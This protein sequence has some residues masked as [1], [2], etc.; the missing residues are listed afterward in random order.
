[1]NP[2]W[3]LL[4]SVG[5][6][7]SNALA[8]SP[9]AGDV[10]RSFPGRTA[11][12]V[13]LASAV[14]GAGT[15]VGALF[16]APKA[17][18]IGLQKALRWALIGLAL[19]LSISAIAPAIW[20]L[21]A[22]QA[23]A[24]LSAGLALPAIY[25]LA[26]DVAPKGRESETL[27]K[28][29]TGWTLS[30]VAGVT[31]SASVSDWAHWRVVYAALAVLTAALIAAFGRMDIERGEP[32]PATSPLQALRIPG[33]P[34]ILFSVIAYMV[35][36]YGLYAYLGTHLTAA[37]GLSTGIAGLAALAY[38]IGFGAI[39][40][41]DRLI[42]RHGAVRSA[43]IV[44]AALVAVYLG[45]AAIAA[46]DLAIFAACLLWGAANHLGLNILVGQLTALSPSRRGAI[47]GLYS[48]VTYIAMFVGTAA[49][50]PVYESYGFAALAFLSAL[51]VSPALVEALRGRRRALLT[52]GRPS[53]PQGDP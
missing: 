32:G 52:A 20:L 43:P 11:T 23:C 42:D 28:V 40:P 3:L 17:D 14:Y 53:Q 31:L 47:L 25:G 29:L 38:G 27:G 36:F 18:R 8:L 48:A 9:I 39:A 33:L 45:I 26:A 19:S 22:A 46:S 7:G 4:F 5:V 41:L 1:M 21:V 6:I 49:F 2:I 34:P 13:M 51:C 16:L 50:K 15:A 24:G 37:L 35:A 10:A 30:L 12:D 44:F